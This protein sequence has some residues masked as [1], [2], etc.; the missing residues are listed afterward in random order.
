MQSGDLKKIEGSDRKEVNEDPTN[1]GGTISLKPHHSPTS[2]KEKNT[3]IESALEEE[4]VCLVRSILKK[5]IHLMLFSDR[6]SKQ[7]VQVMR[8]EE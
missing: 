7:H 1:G 5:S 2:S 3:K 6:L 4:M 8:Y